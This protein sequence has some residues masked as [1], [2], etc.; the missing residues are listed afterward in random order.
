MLITAAPLVE[1]VP[2]ERATMPDR[3]VVQWDKDS[4]EDA[5]L[6]KIDLLSL[7]T[8][9]AVEEALGHIEARHGV[10]LD[11]EQLALDDPVV[12]EMLARADTVGCFQVESRAQAQMQPK[13][14]PACFEDIVIEIALI[15]PGPIQGGMVHPYLRRRQGLEPVTY[16]HPALEPVLAETMGVIVFQ[17][18]VIRVAMAVAGFSPAEADQLRRAM[19]RSRSGAAMEA[20]RERFVA[21]AQAKGAEEE[22]AEEIFRQLAGFAGFGFCKSHAAAFGLVAYQTLYLKAYY[23][24]EFYCA[25]L[26]HQPMGFYPPSVLI[27]AARRHGVPVLRPDIN[28]SRENCTLEGDTAGPTPLSIRLGLR[29]VHGLGET[30]QEQIV[31]CRE[32]EAPAQNRP[33]QGLRDFCRRTRLPRVVVENLI[34]SGALD[35]LGLARR[36][37]LWELG[38]LDYQTPGLDLEVPVERVVLPVLKR[39]EQYSWE[40]ELLGLTPGSHVMDLYRAELQ[41]RGVLSSGQLAGRRDGEIVQTAGFAVVRQRP[42]TA[43]GFLFITLEDEEG[44]VNLIVRP[45]VY[46]RYKDPL[47]NAPLL[48][49]RGKVQREGGAMSVLVYRAAPLV[50]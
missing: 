27:G 41:D 19:S 5:G 18:Q 16:I 40:H 34:R 50:R 29:Y 24:A 6:I 2:L 3:V 4:V 20:L 15:R 1:V 38:I 46:E 36:D 22:T 43:K 31:R 44:L 28:H 48:W 23:P 49:V 42:P 33:Y 14:Q 10:T 17:E 13:M 47:R 11:L 30:G 32:G 12:Y 37:L 35:S 9:G 7:R 45:N 25:L 21:G 39:A 8:L 26:N